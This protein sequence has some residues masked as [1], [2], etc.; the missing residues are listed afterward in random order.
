MKKIVAVIVVLALLVAG[1]WWYSA[2]RNVNIGMKN[3]N[4]QSQNE[5]VEQPSEEDVTQNPASEQPVSQFSVTADVPSFADGDL[6]L[7]A[8]GARDA[9]MCDKITSSELKAKCKANVQE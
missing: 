6:Y 8:L 1:L 9:K 7:K 2:N 3:G 4:V 5:D